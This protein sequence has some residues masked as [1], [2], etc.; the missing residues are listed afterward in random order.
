MLSLKNIS[1]FYENEKI[2]ENLNLEIKQN[3]K[4][5]IT[6]ENGSGKTTLLKII[7]LLDKNFSGKYFLNGKDVNDFSLKEILNLRNEVF[8][9]YFQNFN[10][11]EDETVFYNVKIP[12]IYSKKYKREERNLKV[13][14]ILEILKIENLQNKKVKTLSGG[15]KQKVQI[16]KV[17]VNDPLVLILDEPLSSL[18]EN[19][20]LEMI[21]ILEKHFFKDK[22]L[23]IVLHNRKLI[24]LL[25]NKYNFKIYKLEKGKIV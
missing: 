5:I 18:S 17:L 25:K 24:R 9:L 11:L 3:D 7:A 12:L 4:I 1:K 23:I 2:L 13:I 15:E 6:G 22:T 20:K 8:S 16:A 14:K 21:Y 10:L 19:M